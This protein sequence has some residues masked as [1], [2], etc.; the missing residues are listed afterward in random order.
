MDNVLNF[1]KNIF[2]P[3][4]RFLILEKFEFLSK[5]VFG[6]SRNKNLIQKFNTSQIHG[7]RLIHFIFRMIITLYNFYPN[8]KFLKINLHSN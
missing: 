1:I 5:F 3:I 4:Y 6:I 7:F 2:Y 8:Q